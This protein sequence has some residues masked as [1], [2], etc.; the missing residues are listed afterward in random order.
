MEPKYLAFWRC[1]LHPNHHLTFGDLNP[2][3]RYWWIISCIMFIEGNLMQRVALQGTKSCL[4]HQLMIAKGNVTF[5]TKLSLREY[6]YIYICV[7]IYVLYMYICN[8]YPH[9]TT[10]YSSVVWYQK[11][12][13][14][15]KRCFNTQWASNLHSNKVSLRPPVAI[16]NKLDEGIPFIFGVV[17]SCGIFLLW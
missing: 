7:N 12:V 6:I 13:R 14:K 5:P 11:N 4:R 17:V 15:K 10:I 9:Q 16:A 1:F 3:G 8:M 2:R